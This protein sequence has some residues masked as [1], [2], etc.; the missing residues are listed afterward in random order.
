MRSHSRNRLCIHCGQITGDADFAVCGRCQV[1]LQDLADEPDDYEPPPLPPK[2][3]QI[4]DGRWLLWAAGVRGCVPWFES[5]GRERGFP[6]RLELWSPGM[7][8]L[9]VDAKI[10]ARNG[11]RP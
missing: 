11:A 1:L 10:A 6:R 3:P 4:R 7:V 5:F 8:R 2:P 9:A